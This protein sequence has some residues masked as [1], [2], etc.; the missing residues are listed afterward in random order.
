M[1]SEDMHNHSI[2]VVD[3]E[4]V[5]ITQLE[6]ML[7][8]LGYRVVAKASA[9]SDAV[10]LARELHPDI[11][12][13]DVVMPGEIDG[14]TA[15]GIIQSEMDI[16]VVLLTAY[17][18]ERHVA[19][20]KAVHPY[21]YILKPSQNDQIR[22]TIEI[23]LEKKDMERNLDG[24]VSGLRHTAEDRRLQLK[25]I[26]HRIRNNLNMITSLL[27]LQAL[28]SRSRECVDALQAV[29]SRVVTIARI[30]ERLHAADSAE[31]IDCAGY[32]QSIADAQARTTAVAGRVDVRLDCGEF[33]LEPDKVMPMGLI[34]NELVSNALRH[35]FEDGR[36]GEVRV[37]FAR[38]GPG[39]ELQVSD[40]GSGLPV[41]LNPETS[42]TLGFELVRSL[43]A[44]VGGFMAV[45]RGNGTTFRISFPA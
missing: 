25:E 18:D 30:H 34:L 32:F 10:R 36:T 39:Y 31:T 12:L 13:M 33:H 27:A 26:H 37:G 1:N 44:Q 24:M 14:I 28:H 6:E 38:S 21:G 29:R 40:N 35:A 2:M 8:S 19:R 17:G 5:I 43:V 20:A 3:D 11:V 42:G 41:S 16:P 15:C 7:D 4:G 9:G 45:D 22:A 23:V